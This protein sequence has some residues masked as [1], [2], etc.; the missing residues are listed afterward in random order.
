[1]SAVA[2][3]C[4]ALSVA[5]RKAVIESYEKFERQGFIGDEPCRTVTQAMLKAIGADGEYSSNISMWMDQMFKECLRA[6]YR[7]MEAELYAHEY[8]V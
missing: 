7:R 2:T 4:E 3:F 6:E 5:E 8:G 1:M